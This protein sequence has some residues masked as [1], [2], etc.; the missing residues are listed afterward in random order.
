MPTSVAAAWIPLPA[1]QV[2]L[3]TRSPLKLFAFE[4]IIRLKQAC[5]GNLLTAIVMIYSCLL[6]CGQS[7]RVKTLQ[8]RVCL[9]MHMKAPLLQGND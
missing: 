2:P 8:A 4:V 9:S 1:G 7:T 5:I 6:I 3:A